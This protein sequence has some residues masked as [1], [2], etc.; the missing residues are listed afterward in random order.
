MTGPTSGRLRVAVIGGGTSGEH[1][2][3]LASAASARAA[4]DPSRYQ[5][6]DFTIDRDGTWVVSGTACGVA[7]AMTQ[8]Q[9]CDVALPLVHGAPGED[10]S[11]SALCDFV[12]VPH[13]GPRLRGGAL[14]MDKVATKALAAGLGIRVAAGEVIARGTQPSPWTGPVVV[15]PA[16][17]GSSLGVSLVDVPE[18]LS[19][20]CAAAA[21]HDSRVL[22]EEVLVGREIDV[23]VLRL[24]GGELVCGPPLEI[25]DDG[26][27]GGVFGYADK[28]ARHPD[29]RVP[30]ALTAAETA[31]LTDAAL[32]MAAALESTGVI[33][34]DFFLTEAGPVL[35]EVNTVPGFTDKSQVPLIFAAAGM[36]Y[37]ALLDA[38]IAAALSP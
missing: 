16:S 23:G 9:R 20:A 22:I 11:L 10:G 25:V 14:A 31:A 1:E 33:R 12:G 38:L 34:V 15:K 13:T 27:A 8:L 4:L 3:S 17:A 26:F 35:N 36:P 29:F 30:A 28:Y 6:I 5:P 37:P 2:V 7:D 19:A 21:A 32:R 24:S 18:K